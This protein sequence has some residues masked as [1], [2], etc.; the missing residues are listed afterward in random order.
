[1]FESC[2]ANIRMASLMV[3]KLFNLKCNDIFQ[4]KK[5]AYL[6][7]WWFAVLATNCV[8]GT[9]KTV[10]IQTFKLWKWHKFIAIFS[11]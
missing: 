1:M 5:I 3:Q 8:Y 6:N 2:V 10:E 11:Q 9:M 7:G 4:K